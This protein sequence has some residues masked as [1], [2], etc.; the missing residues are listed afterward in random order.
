M[1]LNNYFSCS[2]L[3]SIGILILP[4]DIVNQK[5]S[6]LITR[7]L[8]KLG[9]QWHKNNWEGMFPIGWSVSTNWHHLVLTVI[10]GWIKTI[11]QKLNSLF[12]R[13]IMAESAGQ[14]GMM[15]KDSKLSM[16]SVLTSLKI[17]PSVRYLSCIC[18][19]YYKF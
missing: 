1:A 7:G 4:V 2:S 8:G 13:Y 9:T 19:F 15:S 11:Y 14:E 18:D 5:V 6:F 10:P 3:F 12:L 16:D 17:Y